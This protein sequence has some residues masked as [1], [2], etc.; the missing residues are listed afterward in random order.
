[1]TQFAA[2]PAPTKFVA[3][4]YLDAPITEDELVRAYAKH[5][6]NECGGNKSTA[7]RVLGIDRRSLYRRLETPKPTIAQAA[8]SEAPG[9]WPPS[10]Y[11]FDEERG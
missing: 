7:A 11:N 2:S 5:V 8:T 1:M 4:I 6:L 10:S 9:G 3:P